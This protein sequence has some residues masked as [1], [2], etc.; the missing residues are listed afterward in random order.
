[1]VYVLSVFLRKS[2]GKFY[3]TAYKMHNFSTYSIKFGQLV[4][5][6][7]FVLLSFSFFSRF[8]SPDTGISCFSDFLGKEPSW[9]NFF[10]LQTTS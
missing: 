5:F 7:F 1:M 3:L 10:L 2:E 4:F 9:F 8:L 6:P